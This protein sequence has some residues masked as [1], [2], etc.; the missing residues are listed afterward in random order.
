MSSASRFLAAASAAAATAA[1]AGQL[2]ASGASGASRRAS[3][4]H[5]RSL[6]TVSTAT[7]IAPGAP[8]VGAGLRLCPPCHR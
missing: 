2:G 3:V 7:R 4:V 5:R 8:K 1:V 6:P